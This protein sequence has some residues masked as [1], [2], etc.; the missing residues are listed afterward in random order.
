MSTRIKWLPVTREGQL[1]MC[2]AWLVKLQGKV[3]VWNIK[4]GTIEKLQ[5]LYDTALDS[6]VVASDKGNKSPNKVSQCNIDFDEM[7]VFMREI[8]SD[9]F[10]GPLLTETDY[11]DLQ[12]KM[13]DDHPTPSGAPLALAYAK[14]SKIG[15]DELTKKKVDLAVGSMS[16]NANYVDGKQKE[17][18]N[19]QFL[20]RY[21]VTALNEKPPEDFKEWK[22]IEIMT[23][24]HEIL[25]LGKETA[26]SVLHCVFRVM[27]GKKMGEYGQ[28]TEM[29]IS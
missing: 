15:I 14:I 22:G 17:P 7:T 28:I 26:G 19:R 29:V 9:A 12:L 10:H 27:N 8:K 4:K 13:H 2:H 21:T 5:T 11:I 24:H 3:D 16:V 23:G 6:L 1:E 25:N 18:H 20:F